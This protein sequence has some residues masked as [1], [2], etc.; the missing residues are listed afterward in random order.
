MLVL[1]CI[2]VKGTAVIFFSMV[3]RDIPM[4]I[5]LKCLALVGKYYICG[6]YQRSYIFLEPRAHT[7]WYLDMLWIV[8]RKFA[9]LEH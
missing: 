9:G 6:V 4:K 1:K 8:S 7:L 5:Y 3:N 2:A